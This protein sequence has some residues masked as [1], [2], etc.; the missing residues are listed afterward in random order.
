MRRQIVVC[1]CLW[2]ALISA[3]VAPAPVVPRNYPEPVG[4]DFTVR[5]FPFKT[6]ERQDVRLYYVTVGSPMKRTDGQVGNAVLLLHGTNAS[7]QQ[8]SEPE[9]RQRAVLPGVPA[10][11]GEI[12]HHP[13]GQRGARRIF[14]AQRRPSR[15]LPA[16]RLRR[17][18]GASA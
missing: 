13:A 6:G 12:L 8:L 18:G 16:L 14:Q 17:H 11:R 3:Q 1:A 5:G 15:K 9:F 7:S 4:A 10:G 2:S